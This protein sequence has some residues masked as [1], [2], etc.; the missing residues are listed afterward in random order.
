MKE[1]KSLSSYLQSVEPEK[2]A[3]PE[4]KKSIIKIL[5]GI[6]FLLLV[7]FLHFL[8]ALSEG[9]GGMCG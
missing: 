5:I 6:I 1:I 2:T 3:Q 7:A 8:Y 4:N 9:L